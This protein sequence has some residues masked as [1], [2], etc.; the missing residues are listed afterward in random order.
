[1]EGQANN[2][3]K[4]AAVLNGT[5]V[6]GDLIPQASEVGADGDNVLAIQN[7]VA[8]SALPNTP[9]V[10]VY[11]DDLNGQSTLHIMRGNGEVIKLYQ[12]AALSRADATSF[13]GNY[14]AT[15]IDIVDNMRTHINELKLKLQAMG[16]LE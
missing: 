4:L 14:N 8:P 7:G 12:E 10:Q 3:E 13:P 15:A 1:M 9:S 5:V 16:Y 6:V 2:G 11:A